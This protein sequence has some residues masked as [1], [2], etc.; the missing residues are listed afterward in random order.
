MMI[1]RGCTTKLPTVTETCT[2]SPGWPGDPVNDHRQTEGNWVVMAISA[3]T[4]ADSGVPVPKWVASMGGPLIVVPVSVLDRWNGCTV[5]GM[6]MSE[7]DTQD[8]YDRACA[9]KGLAG[10]I[11]VGDESA[12]GLVLADGPAST[13]YLPQH[14]TFV[15]WLAADT[16]T[17]VITAAIA[18]LKDPATKWHGCGIWETDGPA[19]LMDS[20]TAGSELAENESGG[21][22]TEQDF[23][24]IRP[25]R[26]A[27]NAANGEMNEKTQ[28]GVIRLVSTLA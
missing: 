6:V 19:M 25:G 21:V 2:T 17:D 24:S 4:T 1:R 27:V 13:C 20:A 23:L 14:S 8:D 11:P 15:R 26:W 22:P 10:V 3:S 18:T 12:G 7:G 9:V 28:V 16:E 5:S